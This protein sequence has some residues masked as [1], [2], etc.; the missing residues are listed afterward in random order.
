LHER[1]ACQTWQTRPCHFH[2]PT[3]RHSTPWVVTKIVLIFFFIIT[4]L[5]A[6]VQDNASS[7]GMD[8]YIVN[9]RKGCTEAI[10]ARTTLRE[11]N[12]DVYAACPRRIIKSQAVKL[13][14]LQTVMH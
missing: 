5:N 4:Q 10:Q 12:N 7:S 11:G 3:S 6:C 13:W 9:V 8:I 2:V 1:I 14:K